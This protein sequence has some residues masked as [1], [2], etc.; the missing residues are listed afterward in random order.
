TKDITVELLDRVRQEIPKKAILDTRQ[1]PKEVDHS[2]VFIVHGRDE[3]AKNETARFVENLGLIA[4]IL[5][6]QV[7]AGD[8]IIDKLEKHT[9]VGFG[10]ILY[11]PCDVG[12]LSGDPA[13]KKRARQN[14]IF[15]HGY[16]IAK[17][18]RKNVCALVTDDVE[19]PNDINGIVYVQLDRH[20]AWRLAIARELR[21]AGYLIDMNKI[22]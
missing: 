10:I 12:G 18:G 22:L 21:N 4:V 13:Q 11:T 9:N 2:R 5:H 14:V 6:E 8:T 20:G 3:A 19:I 15:E 1:L 16:L 7:N 17:L